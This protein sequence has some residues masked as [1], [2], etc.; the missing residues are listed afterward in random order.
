MEGSENMAEK[1]T[2]KPKKAPVSKQP[3][4]EENKSLILDITVSGV[5]KRRSKSTSS[6]RR[7]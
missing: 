4:K 1:K 7:I 5:P 6:H 3:K 2:K